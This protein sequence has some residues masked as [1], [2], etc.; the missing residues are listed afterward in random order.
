MGNHCQLIKIR[1]FGFFEPPYCKCFLGAKA[2]LGLAKESQ[3]HIPKSSN[4]QYLAYLLSLL[5]DTVLKVSE[6]SLEGVWSLSEG[7]VEVVWKVS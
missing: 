5:L 7:C 6:R 4:M 1:H 2:P 3:C